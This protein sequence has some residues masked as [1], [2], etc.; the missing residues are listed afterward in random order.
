M[1][2]EWILYYVIHS[3]KP[4]VNLYEMEKSLVSFSVLL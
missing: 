1:D 4:N 2:L 3:S